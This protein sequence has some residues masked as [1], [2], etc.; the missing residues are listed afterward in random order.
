LIHKDVI[1]E[2]QIIQEVEDKP[3]E[4]RMDVSFDLKSAKLVIQLIGLNG[5]GLLQL[6]CQI[7]LIK[8]DR[9]ST[10][11]AK[12]SDVHVEPKGANML[13]QRDVS[14]KELNLLKKK[15]KLVG[16]NGKSIVS[17]NKPIANEVDEMGMTL[18]KEESTCQKNNP[19][20]KQNLL[21]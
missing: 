14:L 15:N 4:M 20:A 18:D 5:E 19:V 3:L 17:I 12:G 7:D 9:R 8:D 11:V 6:T 16:A 13:M 10:K 21:P 1:N 2:L